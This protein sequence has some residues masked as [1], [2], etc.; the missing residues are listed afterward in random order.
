MADFKICPKCNFKIF[1]GSPRTACPKCGTLYKVAKP[2][3][4][5]KRKSRKR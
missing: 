3:K 4:P 2:R 5:A 1:G